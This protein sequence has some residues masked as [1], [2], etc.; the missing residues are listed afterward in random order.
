MLFSWRRAVSA[1]SAGLFL[2]AAIHQTKKYSWRIFEPNFVADDS[3]NERALILSDF[4]HDRS[5]KEV[6]AVYRGNGG[7]YPLRLCEGDCDIDQHCEGDLVCHQRDRGDDA[8]GCYLN[9]WRR[10]SRTDFCVHKDGG[11]GSSTGGG[12]SSSGGGV[13]GG[14]G[15]STGRETFALKLYWEQG[16][17]W[18]E[19][20][21]ERKWCMRCR[22]GCQAYR[23]LRIVDCDRVRPTQ[24]RFIHYDNKG[25]EVQIRIRDR[26]LCMEVD[27]RENEIFLAPCNPFEEKQRFISQGGSFY[28]YRFEI[29]PKTKRGWC[30][31]QVRQNGVH[32]LSD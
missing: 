4:S 13:S 25:D 7:P 18:Q 11:G 5:L 14:G 29:V 22:S 21:F 10:Y 2:V 28:S 15:G 12:G 6:R 19:E 26:P 23:Q 9:R 3:D 17:Y 31:T 16:Y 24:W 30:L 8:P 32:L 20:R 1:V 27:T